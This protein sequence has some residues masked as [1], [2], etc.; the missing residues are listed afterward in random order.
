MKPNTFLCCL[1]IAATPASAQ[2]PLPT[3]GQ[4]AALP[5]VTWSVGVGYESAWFR[6]VSQTG[7]PVDASPVSWEGRGLALGVQHDRNTAARLHRFEGVFEKA[8]RFS[9]QTPLLALPRFPEDSAL[10]VSGRYEYRRYPFRDLG[11][12]GL[13]VGIGV[14]GGAEFRS[15]VQ[16]FD[17]SIEVRVRGTDLT[18]GVVAAARLSRWRAVQF[19]AAWVNGG[20]IG[21]ATTRHS[22]AAVSPVNGWGG[23]WL[24]DLTVRADVRISAAA[25]VF[26]SYFG[27][28]RGRFASHDALASGQSRF[29]VGVSH[30]R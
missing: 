18:A 10:R 17:P 14:E 6:D 21:R 30:G 11:L 5:A 1:I 7:R 23:G 28:G 15:L 29:I 3:S 27:T 20:A 13:D 8:G 12:T 22:S 25:T 19:Q 24:T 26:A 2:T 9:F 4:P 16:H